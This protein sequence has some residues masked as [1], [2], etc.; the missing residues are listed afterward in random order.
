MGATSCA[1]Y[2]DPPLPMADDLLSP[3]SLSDAQRLRLA[4]KLREMGPVADLMA[5]VMDQLREGN[6]ESWRW[7]E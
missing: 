6:F 1:R 4:G 7:T 5:G 3:A 2:S